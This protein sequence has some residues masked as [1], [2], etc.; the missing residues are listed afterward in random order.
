MPGKPVSILFSQKRLISAYF[1]K[2]AKQAKVSVTTTFFS[3]SIYYNQSRKML[4]RLIL[5]SGTTFHTIELTRYTLMGAKNS[6]F[7]NP[8]LF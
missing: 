4:F 3:I 1:F 5:V 2:Y 8:R 7:T 6:K